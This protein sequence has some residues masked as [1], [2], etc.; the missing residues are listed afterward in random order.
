MKLKSLNK[1]VEKFGLSS[2]FEYNNPDFNGHMIGSMICIINNITGEVEKNYLPESLGDKST[3]AFLLTELIFAYHKEKK[4]LLTDIIVQ[5]D[6]NGNMIPKTV[7]YMPYYVEDHSRFKPTITR[8]DIDTNE[9]KSSNAEIELLLV[10]D[11]LCRYITVN[12]EKLS[13]SVMTD[14]YNMFTDDKCHDLSIKPVLTR[15]G[16]I[17]TLDFYNKIGERTDITF[18]NLENIR[19]LIVSM[20]L[21]GIGDKNE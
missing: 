4:I 21:I 10:K 3:R 12:I 15:I 13:I 2:E 11:D 5:S 9:Y 19:D 6:E 20:R 8:Y 1:G 14:I 17:Y 16:I 18:S 7:Y